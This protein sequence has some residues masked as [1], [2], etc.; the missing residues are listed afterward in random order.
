[1]PIFPRAAY[2][3]ML[4]ATLSHPISASF[5]MCCLILACAVAARAQVQGTNS[6]YTGA[7]TPPLAVTGSMDDNRQTTGPSAEIRTPKAPSTPRINGP[8]IFG[9]R[10]KSLFLYHIPATGDRPIQFSVDN[11]PVG[12]QVNATTGQMTGS[13]AQPGEYPVTLRA[14]NALG[15]DEKKFKIVVGETIALTPPMGWNSWNCWHGSVTGRAILETAHAMASS[16]LIDHGWTYV[17]I[18]DGWQA[19]RGGEFNALQG[20]GKFSDMKRM[21]DQIHALG[22]KAGIYSTPWVTSYGGAPGGSAEN[23]EGTWTKPTGSITPNK[24]LFPWAIGK[25]SFAENDAKQWSA[26][27]FDYFKYDWNPIELPETK[28]M[29]DALRKSGRDV[30]FSI[31]NTTPFG[32]IGD[33]SKVA[34]LWRIGGDMYENGPTVRRLGFGEAKDNGGSVQRWQPYA[35]PGH[36]NDPDMMEIGYMRTG[37]YSHS[38]QGPHMT[39]LTPDE[40]YSQFTLWCVIDAPL[41]ISCDLQH[42]DDFTL[43][44]LTNDEVIA[45]NQDSL[46][47]QAKRVFNGNNLCVYAKDMEDGSKAVGLFNLS[48]APATVTANWADLKIT[49]KKNVRD[50]WRQKDLGSFDDKFEMTVAPHGA[51]L[52]KIGP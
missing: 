34:N 40:Q 13:T 28:E 48:E 18:D 8:D 46:G 1:M 4:K 37:D 24:K 52:V 41:L 35:S 39:R 22:L 33:L 45:V 15:V 32:S 2:A 23:P 49:G 20:N 14:K 47:Q 44:I 12:L 38:K 26:W 19:K 51:E 11:L 3:T 10:P 17:N 7:A 16:G 50:L 31:S 9:V 5:L 43:N 29:Y 36:W 27:G 21:C 30:V 42:L 6:T 25:Y